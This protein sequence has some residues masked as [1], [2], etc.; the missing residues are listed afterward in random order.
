MM[1]DTVQKENEKLQIF[2]LESEFKTKEQQKSLQH[3]ESKNKQQK[4][5]S[6]ISVIL[7]LVV[8]SFFVYALKQRKK[9]NDQKLLTIQQQ[10]KNEVEQALYEGEIMERERIAK[11]LHDGIGGRITGIKIH[12]EN[13]AQQNKSSDL[14]NLTNQL[15]ICLS[16]LRNTARNL[17]PETLKKFGLEE[18]IKDFCQNMSSSSRTISCYVKNLNKITD[19]K[20][21]I[22][23]FHIIQETVNNAVKHSEASKILVQCTFEDNLLLLDIEDNGKGFDVEKVSRGL[24]LNNIEKRVH[25]L[26]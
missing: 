20:T 5:I 3:L 12:L 6:I 14:Q 9:A 2:N 26:N 4:I 11:D 21:Q 8:I 24:G 25:A 7:L 19:Q 1:N 16:E 15:E 10:Q 13:L 17:T 22:H 18:A 23:I